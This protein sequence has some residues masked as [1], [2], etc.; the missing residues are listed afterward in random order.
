MAK[1]KAVNS[2]IQMPNF[3]LKRFETEKHRFYYYDV[4]KNIIGKNGH[5]KSINTEYGYY[6]LTVEEYL[7]KY[8]EEPFSKLLSF[9]DG[10]D[11]ENPNFFL[12]RQDSEQI[13]QF[14]ISLCARDPS[15]I[16][17]IEKHSVYSQFIPKTAQMK[18]DEA[19]IMG[20][21]EAA[22]LGL[23]SE[24]RTTLTVNNTR[25]PFVLPICG[26]YSYS[27][28]GEGIKYLHTNLPISP[29]LAI[30]LVHKDNATILTNDGRIAL[31]RVDEEIVVQR[32]NKWAVDA[33]RKMGWGYVV[34]P[35]ENALIQTLPGNM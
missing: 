31:Y 24:Y 26:L 28:G 29:Y 18:H 19:V 3:M 20:M 10:I 34:S 8:V 6:D 1:N 16:K 27:F 11:R 7:C 22:K 17:E 13:K 25:I 12:R 35:E 14:V 21:N 4:K 2:H 32:M 30:T 23:L 15:M 9:F 5:A 33:Q